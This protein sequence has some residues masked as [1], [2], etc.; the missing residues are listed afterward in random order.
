MYK[1]HHALLKV[2]VHIILDVR[3]QAYIE[4]S[5]FVSMEDRHDNANIT[6]NLY[7]EVHSHIDM[8][9]HDCLNHLMYL[10]M[11]ICMHISFFRYYISHKESHTRDIYCF[12]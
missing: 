9:S 1:L 11:H 12:Q 10:A 5:T 2:L 3:I 4:R 7:H 6:F 8:H